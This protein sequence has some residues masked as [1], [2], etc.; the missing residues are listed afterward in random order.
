MPSSSPFFF[1][2]NVVNLSLIMSGIALLTLLINATT[3]KYLIHYLGLDR[4]SHAETEIFIHSCSVI[5]KKIEGVIGE[6]KADRFLGDA[7]WT[8]VWRYIPLFTSKVYWHRIRLA[9]IKLSEEEKELLLLSS[10]HHS[11]FH[12]DADSYEPQKTLMG[13]K[14]PLF[15]T[16]ESGSSSTKS[17]DPSYSLSHKNWWDYVVEIFIKDFHIKRIFTHIPPRIRSTW[18]GYHNIFHSFGHDVVPMIENYEVIWKMGRNKVHQIHKQYQKGGVTPDHNTTPNNN[19]HHRHKT[20]SNAND[21]PQ[22]STPHSSHRASKSEMGEVKEV[23]EEEEEDSGGMMG[24][25]MKS[26]SFNIRSEEENSEDDEDE[27]EEEEEE[28]E[29]SVSER[30]RSITWSEV[31]GSVGLNNGDIPSTSQGGTGGEGVRKLKSRPSSHA[32]RFSQDLEE[33]E[34]E[35][36]LDEDLD[37]NDKFSF[38]SS[39]TISNSGDYQRIIHKEE[40]RLEEIDHENISSI[41]K[42]QKKRESMD[43]CEVEVSDMVADFGDLTVS[44]TDERIREGRVRVLHAIIANLQ[45]QFKSGSNQLDEV[46]EEGSGKQSKCEGQN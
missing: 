33:G 1:P 37:E 2:I 30:N 35:G 41:R 39:I 3:I 44:E 20:Q 9:H 29:I 24:T 17:V 12:P 43:D 32:Y 42:D 11:I 26:I 7:D 36:D 22:N 45:G 8:V 38:L 34:E 25:F 40:E 23:K 21:S 16:A 19:H 46:A 6:L 10:V 18:I 5:E 4:S 14:K 27:E 15:R 31:L 28:E 13:S